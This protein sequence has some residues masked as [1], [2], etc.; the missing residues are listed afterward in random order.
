MKLIKFLIAI[1]VFF[2][3]IYLIYITGDNSLAFVYFSN[4]IASRLG[5]I[6][7]VQ[8]AEGFAYALL[9]IAE[10]GIFIVAWV[11]FLLVPWIWRAATFANSRPHITSTINNIELIIKPVNMADSIYQKYKEAAITSAISK[12]GSVLLLRSFL[13]AM[14]SECFGLKKSIFFNSIAQLKRDGHITKAEADLLHQLRRAGNI[15]SHNRQFTSKDIKATELT[16]TFHITG[17]LI[18]NWYARKT[19]DNI[20]IDMGDKTKMKKLP[21]K[22]LAESTPDIPQPATREETKEQKQTE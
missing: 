11:F 9:L 19:Y 16:K 3:L 18:Q 22:E 2:N 20:V 17:Q 8:D 12:A 1:L 6:S 15:T 4:S 5:A 7:G 14:I 10:S 21:P 13:E